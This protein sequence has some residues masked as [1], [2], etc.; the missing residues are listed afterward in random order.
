MTNS[1]L[2]ID[3]LE[4]SI[5]STTKFI[6]SL[7]KTSESVPSKDLQHKD[8]PDKGTNKYLLNIAISIINMVLYYFKQ[9]SLN[10]RG[11]Q[12][13]INNKSVLIPLFCYLANPKKYTQ[14]P[15]KT[16]GRKN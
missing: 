16:F 13:I 15:R 4:T 6:Q 2:S 14:F 12:Y 5:I 9:N 7:Y 1:K 10:T 11:K 8:S 3:E